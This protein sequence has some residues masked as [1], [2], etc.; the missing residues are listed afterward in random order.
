MQ[1]MNRM[2]R[3]KVTDV[4]PAGCVGVGC[5][6]YIFYAL[7]VLAFWVIVAVALLRYIKS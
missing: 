1:P 2:P 6:A 4:A 7:C 5:A 3:V